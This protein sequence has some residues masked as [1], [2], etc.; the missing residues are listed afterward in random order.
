MPHRAVRQ[1]FG[2]DGGGGDND[3][4]RF[5]IQGTACI[6]N[7]TVVSQFVIGVEGRP[8]RDGQGLALG[9]GEALV[10][11]HIAVHG[12]FLVVEYDTSA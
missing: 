3:A 10:Q 12:A 6:H 5:A 7:G 2:G 8:L 4:A 11:G 1:A 9:N